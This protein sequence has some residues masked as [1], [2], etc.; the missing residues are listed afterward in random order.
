VITKA[1]LHKIICDTDKLL[2]SED[3]WIKDVSARN[4]LGEEVFSAS[5]HAVCWCFLGALTKCKIKA[6]AGDFSFAFSCIARSCG[7]S[8]PRWNDA[9]ER[10]FADVKAMLARMKAETAP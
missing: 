2:S 4:K 3:K 7:G 1:K 6:A 10:T 8:I 5:P 9:P